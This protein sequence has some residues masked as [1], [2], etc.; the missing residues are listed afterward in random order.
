MT[1]VGAR[2]AAAF[3][4]FAP[5]HASARNVTHVGATEA[6]GPA[7]SSPGERAEALC[8]RTHLAAFDPAAAPT[9]P[10]TRTHVGASPKRCA[11]LEQPKRALGNPAMRTHVGGVDAG[12]S[13][14]RPAIDQDPR[15][16]ADRP[17]P[18][19]APTEAL[20]SEARKLPMRAPDALCVSH[21][22]G[23]RR[24]QRR[25]DQP[26]RR[27]G[28]TWAPADA[29]IRG[30]PAAG[31][32]AMPAAPT[33]RAA[34]AGYA[35]GPISR[36]AVMTDTHVGANRRPALRQRLPSRRGC[37]LHHS[38]TRQTA[39]TRNHGGRCA[40]ALEPMSLRQASAPPDTGDPLPTSHAP[41]HPAGRSMIRPPQR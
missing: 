41:Y 5:A 29:H 22:R 9:R 13:V 36:A 24:L 11:A 23:R 30:A 32:R 6:P 37:D 19:W 28:P 3:E 16:R 39:Q 25:P 35:A 15:G 2:S 14:A 4:R 40:H 26:R 27:P 21:P 34:G 17:G 33:W 1:Q 31:A 10:A 20:R 38:A 18:T 12:G 8:E 7:L